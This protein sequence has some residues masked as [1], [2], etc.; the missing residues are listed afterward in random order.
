MEL[1]CSFIYQILVDFLSE[2]QSDV[3]FT[4]KFLMDS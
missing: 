3:N 2:F 4:W 1:F